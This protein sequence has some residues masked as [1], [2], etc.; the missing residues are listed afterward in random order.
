MSLAMLREELRKKNLSPSGNRG[1]LVNRLGAWVRNQRILQKSRKKLLQS[2]SEDSSPERP[3]QSK[4][5]SFHLC[6]DYIPERV[7]SDDT[8]S[9][10]KVSPSNKKKSRSSLDAESSPST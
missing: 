1:A 4:S 6:I 10:K 2:E 8:T 9:T 3:K 7:G 5:I